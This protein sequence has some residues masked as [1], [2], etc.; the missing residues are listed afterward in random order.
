MKRNIFLHE[1]NYFFSW[2]E[3]AILHFYKKKKDFIRKTTTHFYPSPYDS[4]VRRRRL[5]R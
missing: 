4:Y 3:I 2:K 1:N 5:K